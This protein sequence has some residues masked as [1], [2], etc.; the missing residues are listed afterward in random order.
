M[1]LQSFNVVQ[2]ER[3]NVIVEFSLVLPVFFILFFGAF[4]LGH[5]LL[6]HEKQSLISREISL[7]AGRTCFAERTVIVNNACIQQ[8][9]VDVATKIAPVEPNPVFAI[10]SY[11]KLGSAVV[12]L[13]FVAYPNIAAVA[14]RSKYLGT[15]APAFNG[16]TQDGELI[17]VG[18][19]FSTWS[20]FWTGT[21]FGFQLLGQE[22]Y[23]A[24]VF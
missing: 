8:V 1:S 15:S 23:E 9:A 21:S 18:E 4:D 22:V 14:T 16:L 5:L 11:Q 7:I 13:G 19:V 12:P 17:L 20:P 24:T 10:F 2:G 6:E 3:G